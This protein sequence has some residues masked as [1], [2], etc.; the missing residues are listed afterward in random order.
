MRIERSGVNPSD[1]KIRAGWRP[2]VTRPP[3]PWI[4]PN[5]DGAGV[6]AAVGDRGDAGCVC[7]RAWV[8]NAQWQRAFG[9]AAE[10][11]TL[12]QSQAVPMPLVISTA[13]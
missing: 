7:Q 3:F 10:Y 9:T 11:V 12:P 4:I 13:C 2:G 5:S 6:I 1:V 8:W